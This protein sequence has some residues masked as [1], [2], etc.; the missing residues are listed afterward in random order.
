M[1]LIPPGHR[2]FEIVHMDHMGPFVTSARG[3]KYVFVIVDNLT[4]FAIV[5]AVKDTKTVNVLRILEEFVREYG[6]P[7]RIV[8]D[9]G[10]CFT[11]K[12]FE[13]FCRRHGIKHTVNSPRHPQANGQVER[14]DA[15]LLPAIQSN[16]SNNDGKTWD[17]ELRRVQSDI[18]EMKHAYTGKSPFE[19]V[20]GFLPRRDEGEMRK[21]TIDNESTYQK[22][23]KLRED[24][25]QKLVDAQAKYKQRH[26]LNRLR[27]V[28][29]NVGS[30]VYMKTVPSATGE[31]TKLHAKYRG[32]LIV[33]EKL[34]GDTY[35]VCDL[36]DD[37]KGRRYASTAHASQMKLWQP[38]E[39]EFEEETESDDDSES[40]EDHTNVSR[41]K[42]NKSKIPNPRTESEKDTV[43]ELSENQ[44]NEREKQS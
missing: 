10:T 39:P 16:L 4:K 1:H 6:A 36:N 2:P 44:C 7:E 24:A 32:P 15:T 28:D 8:S 35:R 22:P 37:E 19:L 25:R 13:E 33:V 34:L 38:E 27:N 5:R 12:Q 43:D 30:I 9:R 31:S 26:D 29:F 41:E 3:N 23:E 20:Y 11:S 40:S 18:N 21:V 42:K 17:R 14:W